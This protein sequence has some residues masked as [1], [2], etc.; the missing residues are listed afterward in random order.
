MTCHPKHHERWQRFTSTT[1]VLATVLVVAGCGGYSP[2]TFQPVAVPDALTK[3]TTNKNF[4]VVDNA[5]FS[6]AVMLYPNRTQKPVHRI[7][8]G[9]YLL[10]RIVLALP[11]DAGI[12]K[13]RLAQYSNVCEGRGTFGPHL[14]CVTKTRLQVTANNVERTLDVTD[15]ADVGPVFIAGDISPPF[16]M[17]DTLEGPIHGQAR[18]SV[19]HL[20]PVVQK[21]LSSR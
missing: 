16:T 2:I 13:V 12:S 8:V 9:D 3:V 6:D 19:D 14:W 15:E 11:Q 10:S 21:A 1:A 17:G 20:M 5:S 18:A 4:A 7:P